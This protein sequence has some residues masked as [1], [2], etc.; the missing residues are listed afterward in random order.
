MM[1]GERTN[2]GGGGG[3]QTNHKRY[4]PTTGELATVSQISKLLITL[5]KDRYNS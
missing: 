4:L 2:L 5:K 3:K 1:S